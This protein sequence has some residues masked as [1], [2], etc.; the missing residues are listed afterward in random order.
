M[1]LSVSVLNAENKKQMINLLNETDISY[2][3]IDVMDGKFV[4]Q[5][6]LPPEE[7][8]EL[9][10]ISTKKLDIHLMVEDPISYIEQIKDLN[11]IEYI[12]IHL[13]I[14]KDIKEILLKIKSYGYKTGLSIKPNTDV[15]ALIPYLEDLDLILLMTVEPG[16]GG[17]PFIETSINKIKELKNLINNTNIKIEVD[18]GIN[19][20]TIKD[21]KEAN[22]AVV[23][24]YITK[25]ENPTETINNLLV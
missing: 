17:Q 20:K 8:I 2:I 11:D 25:S 9:S 6:S 3:H 7:I 14:D 16:L 15:N 4:H 12:T 19:N 5:I 10:S 18:G 22:I 24:S 21:V 1:E 13:E 23:G